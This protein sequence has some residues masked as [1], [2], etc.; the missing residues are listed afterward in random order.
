MITLERGGYMNNNLWGARP[1]T[2]YRYY[3]DKWDGICSKCGSSN[4]FILRHKIFL[5]SMIPIFP[6]S[7]N[8]YSVCGACGELIGFEGEDI[9]AV[10]S[11]IKGLK[12]RSYNKFSQLDIEEKDNEVRVGGSINELRYNVALHVI[13]MQQN[14][15]LK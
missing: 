15:S 9:T 12:Y 5:G 6:I 11:E 1:Y 13:D 3:E 2:T 7:T 8:Y 14:N 10:K 4:R